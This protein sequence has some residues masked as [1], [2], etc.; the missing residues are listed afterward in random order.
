M[1]DYALLK[2]DAR[3]KLQRARW[4]VVLVAFL[5]ALLSGMPVSLERGDTSN[6][7]SLLGGVLSVM[8]ADWTGIVLLG[9]FLLGLAA[10]AYTILVGNVIKVGG[11]GWMLRHHRGEELPL[12]EMFAPFK[13]NYKGTMNTMFLKDITVY[14]WSLLFVIPGIVKSYAYCMVPYLLRDNPHL[15][16]KRALEISNQMTMGHKG[17]IFMMHLSFIG[18]M[19]LG[20]LTAGILN[21]AYVMPYMNLTMAGT[22]DHL[23]RLAIN[24]GKLSC[25]D[26]GV[27]D[28]ES[29]SSA[30]N[31]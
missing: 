19:L 25:Y 17:D 15:T 13:Q 22:Y 31:Q 27:Y 5:T 28:E 10:I 14:L 1:F 16:P 23:K 21:V 6:A 26:L 9:G 8:P 29:S 30:T 18:W 24:S 4:V 20:V 3:A 7:D 12:K 11:A 2:E